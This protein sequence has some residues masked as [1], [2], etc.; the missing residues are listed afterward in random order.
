MTGFVM[1]VLVLQALGGLYQM[2]I[3]MASH[4]AYS[5]A[6]ATRLPDWLVFSHGL[7]GFVAAGLWVGQLVTGDERYA[8][9]TFVVL[10]LAIAGGSVMFV[11]TELRSER[12]HRAAADPADVLVVEKQI[13]KTVLHAHGLGAAVLLASVLYV[14]IAA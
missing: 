12:L 5:R 6:R 8:W 14:A 9:S 1:A 4:T 2:A 11:Q 13:P 3:L 10:L 7:L